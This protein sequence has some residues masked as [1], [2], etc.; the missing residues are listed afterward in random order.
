MWSSGKTNP[1][2]EELFNR[3]SR[4][5]VATPPP[6]PSFRHPRSQDHTQDCLQKQ[7]SDADHRLG[8]LTEMGV[9]LKSEPRHVDQKLPRDVPTHLPPNKWM[10]TAECATPRE[11]S[12][13]SRTRPPRVR[14][15]GWQLQ[16]GLRA[17]I[18]VPQ[19]GSVTMAEW[20][21]SCVGRLLAVDRLRKWTEQDSKWSPT[22]WWRCCCGLLR[23]QVRVRAPCTVNHQTCTVA[24]KDAVKSKKFGIRY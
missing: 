8:V 21:G 23:H 4:A 13:S 18:L 7:A 17:R 11:C 10:K 9:E 24:G 2:I 5:A 22:S 3:V 6:S 15:Q 20:R 1:K 12:R 16:W 19:V 14:R